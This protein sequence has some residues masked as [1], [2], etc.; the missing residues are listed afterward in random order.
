MKV[1]PL[2]NADVEKKRIAYALGNLMNAPEATEIGFGDLKDDRLTRSIDLIAEAYELKSQA[3]RERG[4][5]PL[6]PAAQGRA[7]DPDQDQLS[8]RSFDSCRRLIRTSPIT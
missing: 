6:V 2:I 3:D 5:Q 4:V 7:Y 8:R 1:E